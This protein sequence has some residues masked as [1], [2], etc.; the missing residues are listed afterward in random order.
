VALSTYLSAVN[1]KCLF[2]AQLLASVNEKNSHQTVA[3]VQSVALQLYQSWHWHL[4]DIA[5]TYKVAEPDSVTDVES[6]IQ[7]LEAIGKCPVEAMEMRTLLADKDSW[8]TELLAAH[9]QLYQLPQI[10]KAEMDVDRLPVIAVDALAIDGQQHV[11]WRL[12]AA[13]YWLD[14]MRELVDRHRDMMVEF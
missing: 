13:Q 12:D 1:Q 4:C 14:R 5:T 3:I 7:L 2:A 10:R 8:A 6:L 9:S 11:E